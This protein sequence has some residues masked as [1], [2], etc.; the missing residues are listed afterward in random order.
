[1]NDIALEAS[2]FA[3]FTTGRLTLRNRIVMAPMTRSRAVD[4]RATDD[5]VDYYRQRAGAGL[6][7]T[8]GT[9]PS[10][11]GQGYP[12]T[13]GLHSAAQVEAWAKVTAAVHEAGGT[14]VAQLMHVGRLAHP[15]TTEAAGHGR[16]TPVAPSAI[17]ARGQIHTPTGQQDLVTPSALTEGQ[18]D[19][20]IADFA[21][22][23][24]N[25][26]AAGFD[27]VE[28]HGANGYLLHQFLSANANLRTDRWGGSVENRLRFPIAVVA[29]VA[30]AIGADRTGL[31]ISPNNGLGDTDEPDAAAVYPQLVEALDPIGLAYLHLVEAGAPELT[32]RIRDAWHSAL[33][34]NPV[35]PDLSA[36]SARLDLI[37]GGTADLVSFGRLFIANPDLVERLASGAELASPDMTKAYGGGREGYADYP[38]LDESRVLA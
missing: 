12:D 32:P 27:G 3:P 7:I 22:A 29:A 19:E 31:R 15:D 20:T 10:P 18:V 25:A 34:L 8:E 9:Q 21:A 28:V 26:I 37:T 36:H 33:L 24:E 17:A 2:P 1:M 16:L 38:A 23:A 30:A 5:M 35:G 14:I 4:T 6:I 11:I 13:P